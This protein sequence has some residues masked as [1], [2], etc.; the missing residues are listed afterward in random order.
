MKYEA[1]NYV[2]TSLE[3]KTATYSFLDGGMGKRRKFFQARNKEQSS[4]SKAKS[5]YFSPVQYETGMGVSVEV[6]PPKYMPA[7]LNK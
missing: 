1:V 2:S 4:K 7:A 6:A 3:G 5:G